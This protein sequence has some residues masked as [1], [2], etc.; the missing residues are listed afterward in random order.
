[1]PFVM[2]AV[3][4]QR[5]SEFLDPVGGALANVTAHAG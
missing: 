2:D 4:E 5:L 3:G 1:M